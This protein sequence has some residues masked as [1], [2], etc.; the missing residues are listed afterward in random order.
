MLLRDAQISLRRG[1][2]LLFECFWLKGRGNRQRVMMTS[3]Q[4]GLAN[5]ALSRR[6]DG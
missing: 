5:A 2:V 3:L 4:N 1:Q 6:N